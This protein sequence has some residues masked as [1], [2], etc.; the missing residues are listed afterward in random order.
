[1]LR[2]LNSRRVSAQGSRRHIRY[3]ICCQLKFNREE[4][5]LRKSSW[6]QIG[7]KASIR[8]VLQGDVYKFTS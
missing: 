8:F 2:V 6:F 4:V 3:V 7:I 1:M 5:L